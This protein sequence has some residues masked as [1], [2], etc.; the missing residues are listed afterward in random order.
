M[1]D[2][3]MTPDEAAELVEDGCTITF[4]GVS[5]VRKPM[6]F[7][8]ALIK[9][10]K[11]GLFLVDRE[12]GMDFDIL[13]AAKLVRKIRT[14]MVGFELFGLAPNVRR[15]AE[16]GEIEFVEDTCGAI[17]NAFRAAAMGV[18]FLP[19]KG[20]IG[21]DLVDVH[22]KLGNWKVIE[23]PFGGG[24]ILAVKALKPDV[25]VIHVQKAD[26]YGNSSIEGSRFEDVYKA[27]GAKK[28]IVTA[29]EIVPT[30]Y[31]KEHPERNTIPYFYVDAVVHTPKG[32]YPT[33]C[34]NYYPSD[35]D[36]VRRYL[37][38]CREGRVD[39][40]IREFVGRW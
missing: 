2:K 35:Y 33:A 32:A 31:F 6:A 17:T 39:D 34:P 5:M 28:V 25:A 24:K 14:A 20:I 26:R 4:S 27:K 38:A 21:T 10:G 15:A 12:P 40:Y 9:S 30:D 22:V 11:K 18:P 16:S 29:E 3:L 23:D 8:A 1:K 13:V 36:E 7:I 37:A 19:V